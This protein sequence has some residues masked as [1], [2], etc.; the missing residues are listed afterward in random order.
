M[1]TYIKYKE[2]GLGLEAYENVA[3]SCDAQERTISLIDSE[4]G[5]GEFHDGSIEISFDLIERV[6][7]I[8]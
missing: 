5:V 7:F 1:R 4:M 6:I 8:P 3:P 2:G